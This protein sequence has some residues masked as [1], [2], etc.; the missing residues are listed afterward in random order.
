MLFE[1]TDTKNANEDF[2]GRNQS[3]FSHMHSFTLREMKTLRCA[4]RT[5]K[6]QPKKVP[7]HSCPL[8]GEFHS[9]DKQCKFSDHITACVHNHE[10]NETQGL[11]HCPMMM[12]MLGKMCAKNALEFGHPSCIR[13]DNKMLQRLYEDHIPSVLWQFNKGVFTSPLPLHIF[14][15]SLK[16]DISSFSKI[17]LS[18]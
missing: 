13:L 12:M 8:L 11:L 16:F 9:F 18:C 5:I 4:R 10:L 2:Y 6:S 3:K 17:L 15:N 14:M 1:A 7:S